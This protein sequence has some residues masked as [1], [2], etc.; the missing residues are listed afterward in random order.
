[1]DSSSCRNGHRTRVLGQQYFRPQLKPRR[2]TRWGHIQSLLHSG[3]R[4]K[5]ARTQST[6]VIGSICL[7]SSNVSRFLGGST[8]M[9]SVLIVAFSKY[10][11]F[12]LMATTKFNSDWPSYCDWPK[13]ASSA[14]LAIPAWGRGSVIGH[15]MQ[16]KQGT[17]W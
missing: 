17:D 13:Y 12:L 4:D 5:H 14:F 11:V 2:I 8:L 16:T 7:G 1:M 3:F 9:A 10:N 6:H 15:R